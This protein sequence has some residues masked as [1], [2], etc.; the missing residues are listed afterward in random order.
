MSLKLKSLFSSVLNRIG[1]RGI[2]AIIILAA[3]NIFI[4][5]IPYYGKYIIPSLW[6]PFHITE[7][8]LDQLTVIVGALTLV[9]QLPGGWLADKVKSKT[10]IISSLVIVAATTIWFA[11]IVITGSYINVNGNL[12]T[13]QNLMIQYYIIFA[14]WGAAAA[15]GFWAPMWKL[16]TQQAK[17]EDQGL[18]YGIQGT[19][20]GIIG[21]LLFFLIGFILTT[22]IGI[23]L[24]FAVFSFVIAGYLFI[25]AV[26]IYFIVPEKTNLEKFGID[27]KIIGQALKEPRIWLDSFF[28]MGMYMFQSVFAYYFL[29][30]LKNVVSNQ[31]AW[32]AI[33]VTLLAGFRTYILGFLISAPVGFFVDRA[34][35]Y[36]RLLLI[37]MGISILVST[38]FIFLP[39]FQEFNTLPYGYRYFLGIFFVLIYLVVG[40]LN[41]VMIT[42]RYATIGE[43]PTPKKSY[44]S[45]NALIS[46]IAFSPDAWLFQI[47]PVV[48]RAYTVEGSTNTSQ[49]G[50]TI[51]LAIGIAVAFFG[52]LCGLALHIWNTK[53]LKKLGKTDY[54]WREL[55]NI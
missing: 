46:V 54:R 51:I 39:G 42:L 20:I 33:I 38:L 15:L 22:I 32:S 9:M 16:V 19:S 41:W 4:Y 48:G 28:I 25:C 8:D 40:S 10:L 13:D 1:K 26:L 47:N 12:V 30:Y 52:W 36:V 18:A 5:A 37:I 53:E 23:Q 3:A 34:K 7:S 21:L 29:N 6:E 2:W 31:L 27:F 44:S 17:K 49:L 35:S 14:I 45:V 24:G 43:I 11:V 55:Q 50:Y